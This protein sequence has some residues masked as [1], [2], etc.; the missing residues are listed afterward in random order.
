MFNSRVLFVVGAGASKEV[1]LPTGNE[2][3]TIISH[4]VNFKLDTWS[5]NLEL[6]DKDLF[7]AIRHKVQ[8]DFVNLDY[9]QFASI[10]REM[11]Y[12]MPL[13]PSIDNYL[14][15]HRDK[16][17]ELVGKLAITLSILQ[18]EAKSKL[19]FDWRSSSS[20]MK[21]ENLNKTWYSEF[22][23]ILIENVTRDSLD[24][25]F[26]NIKFIVFNYDRCIEHFLKFALKA[27][28]SIDD[29]HAEELV[30]KLV[31]LRPYGRVS[32]LEW[33]EFGGIRFGEYNNNPAELLKCSENIKTFT[34]QVRDED[35]LRSIHHAIVN[36]DIAVF[37]G[38]GFHKLN[39]D[40]LN[41]NTDTTSVRTVFASSLGLSRTSKEIIKEELEKIF[42]KAGN[43]VQRYE[44]DGDYTCASLFYEHSRLIAGM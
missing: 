15:A 4:M 26:S 7:N 13:A 36:S 19:F 25:V 28:Y 9:R 40:L 41:P 29:Y 11:A 8:N 10:G 17:I 23:R 33:E 3:K 34:E 39:I 43:N 1:N 37:L 32:P 24:S 12:A 22:I 21:F 20:Y 5:S 16:D 2:L 27:Y 30:K 18:A 31:I 38:F 42:N 14:D 35:A 6:G 44:I